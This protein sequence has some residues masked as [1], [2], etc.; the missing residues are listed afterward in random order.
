VNLPKLGSL[1]VNSS[2]S[3]FSLKQASSKCEAWL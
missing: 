1:R 2:V 3:M